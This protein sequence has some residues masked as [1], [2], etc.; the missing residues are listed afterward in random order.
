MSENILY[1]LNANFSGHK[2]STTDNYLTHVYY[3]D[4][5]IF[6][7]RKTYPFVYLKAMR[8]KLK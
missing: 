4:N 1:R 6:M 5:K 7:Y 8:S 3:N 2:S